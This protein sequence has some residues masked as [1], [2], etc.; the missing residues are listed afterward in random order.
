MRDLRIGTRGSP[1]AR[2]QAEEV[3]RALKAHHL[4]TSFPVVVVRTGGD[5]ARDASLEEL[6]RGI[7]TKELEEALLR[8]QVDL[9]VH[10]LKDLPA[11]LPSGL[12]LAAVPPRLDARDVVVSRDGKGLSKLSSGA[13]V[14]TSSPRRAALV[15]ALRRDLEAVPIRGNVDT[16]VRKVL[17]GQ[18]DAA[19]LAAAGLLR[20]GLLQH[21][22]EYLDPSLFV[23]EPGQG[24]LGIEGREE[25]REALEVARAIDHPPTRA[26]VTAERAFLEVMGG[27]CKVPLAA[28]GEVR[29]RWLWLVGLAADPEG[30]RV[31][32]APVTG[33]LEDPLEGG[34]RLAQALLVPGAREMVAA[35]RG[36]GCGAGCSGKS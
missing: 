30:G 36:R 27:G 22:A 17:T 3:V 32:R 24:A 18:Y 2:I 26:A 4:G 34:R 16:R 6:G 20:L 15:K 21:I 28:Y 5:T 7:F 31:M 23:P 33:P 8:G 10:S 35:A 29:D 12:T 19:I 13:R 25:D 1:L 11:R 9:A 14:G